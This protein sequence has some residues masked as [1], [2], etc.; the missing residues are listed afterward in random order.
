MSSISIIGGGRWARTI[1]EVLYWLE[2]APAPIVIHTLRNAKGVKT[3]IDQ[4]RFS[5]RVLAS[6]RLPDF[7]F[8]T[9]TAVIV[10]NDTSGHYAAT[11]LALR[12]GIPVFVEKPVAIGRH[13]VKELCDLSEDSR[14]VLAASH[15]FLFARYLDT[16]ATFVGAR[17]RLRR[18]SCVW[19]DGPSDIRRGE[20]KSYD[21]SV[22]VFDDVLPH[23]MPILER[24]HPGN[25]VLTSLSAQ[26]GGAR[27]SLGAHTK[28]VEITI[29]LARNSGSRRRTIVAETEGG[30]YSLD[31]SAEPGVINGPGIVEANGDPLWHSAPR[32]VMAMLSAFLAAARGASFDSRLS[33]TKA[34]ASAT[35]AD[36]IRDTYC[37]QQLEWLERRIGTVPDKAMNYALLET[38]LAPR[39]QT[40]DSPTKLRS[41][42]SNLSR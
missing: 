37:R 10:A 41:E 3:W 2:D 21:P 5:G 35:F 1:A 33:P 9:P 26:C 29:S 20:A 4:K 11:S 36:S 16:F 12:A 25:P 32:P 8:E 22:T 23:I 6:S 31:F 13:A 38:G 40:I 42:L 7:G 34:L 27:I 39:W 15:V 30:L 19:N 14:T 24:L 17:G 18:L 28:E